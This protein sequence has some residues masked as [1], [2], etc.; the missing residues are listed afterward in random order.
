MNIVFDSQ[1]GVFRMDTPRTSYVCAVMDHKWLGNVYYGPRLSTTD[2]GWVLRL[3]TPKTPDEFPREAVLFHDRFP[4]E[5]PVANTG[6]F[7]EPCLAVETERGVWDCLPVFESYEILSGKPAL[8]GLPATFG[9]ADDCETLKITL[10][11]QSTGLTAELFY[12]VFREIDAI[13]RSV[14]IVNGGDAPVTLRRALSAALDLDYEEGMEILTLHGSWG[15]ERAIQRTPIGKGLTATGSRRGITSHQAQPFMAVLSPG[16][17]QERGE[18]RAMHLV[19]SGSFLAETERGELDTLR[20]N[21]GIQ[22]EQFS[23]RLAPGESFQTPEAVLVY[24]DRG[25]GG[26]TRTLHDLYRNHLIRSVWRDRPRPVLINNWEGTYFRFDEEKLLQIAEKAAGLGIEL[27]VLDDGWFGKRDSD[28]SSLGDWT[29][30][31]RKLPNGLRGLAEKINAL[32][33]KF[34]LWFEPE[35]VSPDSELY[36]AHPDW[37]IRT[38]GREPHLSRE[39]L[40]LDLSRPEVEE[41][42]FEAVAR[43]LRSAPIDYVKWDMNRSLSDLGSAYLP[44]ERQGELQ[45]RRVLAV[46]RLQ[47]RLLAEFPHLL[48]ENCSGGGGRFD[49]GMLYYSPQIWTSDDMDPMERLAIQEGTALLYPLSTMGAHVCAVPNHT[50]GRTTPLETRAIVA[51]LGTFG[52]EL[53]LTTLSPEELAAIPDQIRRYKEHQ[54]L[55]QSGGYYRIRSA[56]DGGLDAQIV[57]SKDKSAALLTVVRVLNRPNRWEPPLKLPGLAPD[58]LYRV[59][60][61]ERAYS[62]E[63]LQNVGLPVELPWHD[64]AAV[65]L[66]LEKI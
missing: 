37:A 6:D 62:G 39:Q 43:V 41:Y 17:D 55:L 60:G 22:P 66:L 42:V 65:Q 31:R 23:W 5:Y 56:S 27:F 24:S 52:Y 4:H 53:D 2:L 14:R 35:M 15:R 48:L 8:P 57:V 19:Y 49:P 1:T 51:S 9:G 3:R 34:G 11:D 46:Y 54:P 36:R 20:M 30:D 25:L 7:R 28:N 61:E 13:T 16:T 63:V 10:R 58:A 26:M 44:P 50:V 45:H 64:F 47:E 12:T 33:M 59:Q 40:V 29:E 21:I 18:V 32:G 38:P